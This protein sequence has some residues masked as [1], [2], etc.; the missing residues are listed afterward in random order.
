MLPGETGC[1][2]RAEC[3]SGLAP[4]TERFSQHE[5]AVSLHPITLSSM[6]PRVGDLFSAGQELYTR[7]RA[8]SVA[9]PIGCRRL[10][11]SCSV[12]TRREIR[13]RLRR[14]AAARIGLLSNF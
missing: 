3:G 10:C 9:P 13:R 6:R 11:T 8:N 14:K 4:A 2:A 5:A 12:R 7:H 1:G